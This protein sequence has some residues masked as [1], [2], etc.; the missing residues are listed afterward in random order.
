M[1]IIAVRSGKST[2]LGVCGAYAAT[3]KVT[4]PGTLLE[5]P[6]GIEVY[7]SVPGGPLSSS[8]TVPIVVPSPTITGIHSGGE[9]SLT[10]ESLSP[11]VIFIQG[12]G[13]VNLAA[14]AFLTHLFETKSNTDI[15]IVN[16]LNTD[17]I[18]V[19]VPV[20]LTA[21][22]GTLSFQ[23]VNQDG[24]IPHASNVFDLPVV[25]GPW[26]DPNDV[27]P[28]L[29][30]SAPTLVLH[31]SGLDLPPLGGT[32]KAIVHTTTGCHAIYEVVPSAIT[33]SSWTLTMPPELFMCSQSHYARFYAEIQ[34]PGAK[35][36]NNSAEFGT[37][38]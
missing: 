37:N 25:E 14:P 23:L 26:L 15:P 3:C 5:E 28:T 6:G 22:V 16:R 38:W 4:L 32:A 10:R 9:P 34:I 21:N 33:A 13:I 30:P 8:V 2:T 20:A 7:V 27:F 31:G 24:A 18:L 1:E 36:C 19:D 29:T 17:V 11:Q 35:R 12:N